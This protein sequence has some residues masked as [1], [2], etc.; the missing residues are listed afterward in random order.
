MV[1]QFS[2]ISMEEQFNWNFVQYSA[3]FK[4]KLGQ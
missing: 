3:Y 2:W 1:E 4:E